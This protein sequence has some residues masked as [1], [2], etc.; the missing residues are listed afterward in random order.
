MY[1]SSLMQQAYAKF[2][3]WFADCLLVIVKARLN[4]E[5]DREKDDLTGSN[6]DS[7][8][9]AF[10]GSS[11]KVGHSRYLP[12]FYIFVRSRQDAADF[13]SA[14][15][16]RRALQNANVHSFFAYDKFVVHPP[17]WKLPLETR[18]G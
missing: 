13:Q 8:S 6:R 10:L 3:P 1:F 16:R 5:S 11:A 15:R 4:Q 14:A 18:I 9:A 2:M 7:P 17:N 12:I